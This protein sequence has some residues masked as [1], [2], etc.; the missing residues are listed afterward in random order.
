MSRHGLENLDHVSI[1]GQLYCNGVFPGFNQTATADLQLGCSNPHWDHKSGSHHSDFNPVCQ[2][3]DVK[4]PLLLYKAPNCFG[5]TFISN[6]L[7]RSEQPCHCILL[8]QIIANF[9]HCNVTFTLF[10]LY[11]NVFSFF[12]AMLLLQYVLTSSIFYAKHFELPCF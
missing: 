5:T 4:V 11:L 3:T 6:L 8:N 7:Q 2:R 12:F 10:N 9:L 1:C